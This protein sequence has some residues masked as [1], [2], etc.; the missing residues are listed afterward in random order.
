MQ[1][2]TYLYTINNLLVGLNFID[3]FS[4]IGSVANIKHKQPR[5]LNEATKW[6]CWVILVYKINLP[7]G[8]RK[9]NKPKNFLK[10]FENLFQKTKH[11][12]VVF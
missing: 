6:K 12:N 4:Q 5:I 11:Q 9:Q 8:N 3:K 10:S 1:N 2:I 7:A